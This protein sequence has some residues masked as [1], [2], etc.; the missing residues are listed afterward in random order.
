M[1][2]SLQDEKAPT[3]VVAI[4]SRVAHSK[5][6]R[7]S[8]IHRL[9]T[10]IIKRLSRPVDLQGKTNPMSPSAHVNEDRRTSEK[11]L[12]RVF[13]KLGL[14]QVPL[15]GPSDRKATWDL[16]SV[17]STFFPSQQLGKLSWERIPLGHLRLGSP[18][19]GGGVVP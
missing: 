19:K 13:G 18:L 6:E 10:N 15:S 7:L 12:G 4:P 5:G 8:G 16:W 3:S 1:S 17:E 11:S 9:I 2:E 14:E